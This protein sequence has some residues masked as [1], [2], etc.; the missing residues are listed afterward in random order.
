VN[1]D[2][3]AN[4]LVVNETVRDCDHLR[5]EV[6]LCTD[7]YVEGD[8]EQFVGGLVFDLVELNIHIGSSI[9]S[10]G[11]RNYGAEAE[12]GEKGVPGTLAGSGECQGRFY[13]VDGFHVN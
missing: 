4:V 11:P 3:I 13:N 7:A 12:R 2:K 5:W 10:E 9:S 8:A 1:I 6:R